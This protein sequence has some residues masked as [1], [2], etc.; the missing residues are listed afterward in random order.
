MSAATSPR[1]QRPGLVLTGGGARAAYQV[2]VLKGLAQL[3]PGRANPFHVIVGTSAG[4]VTAA[5]LASQAGRWRQAIAQ[6]E[7]VWAGFTVEQVF[8]VSAGAMIGS[9]LHWLASL[10]TGGWLVPP[11]GQRQCAYMYWSAV[12][13]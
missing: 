12:A 9:G 13:S 2:G 4:A 11:A 7:Q 10:V 3:L 5:V 8:E 6:T 1:S